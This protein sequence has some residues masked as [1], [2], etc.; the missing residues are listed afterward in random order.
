MGL[1]H[2]E[3][4]TQTIKFTAKKEEYSFTVRGLTLVDLTYLIG[5]HLADIEA[6]WELFQSAQK[7]IVRTGSLDGF[8]LTLCRDAP[9]LV[10]EVISVAADERDLVDR[11]VKLP[12][13]ITVTSLAAVVRLSMVE[14]GDLGN[15]F[16]SIIK[17]VEEALPESV[18][19]QMTAQIQEIKSRAST[20]E[21][22]KT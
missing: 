15:L 6:A 3:P 10:A 11:Y 12:F 1:A 18:R 21:S 13:S 14:H 17:L 2:F 22:E 9:G 19:A 8:Y 16:A 4:E 5:E 7:D 20:G